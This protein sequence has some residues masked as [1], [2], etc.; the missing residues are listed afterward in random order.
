MNSTADN[1]YHLGRAPRPSGTGGFGV[2]LLFPAGSRPTTQALENLFES[3]ELSGSMAQVSH[4]GRDGEGWLEI[5]VGGLIFDLR[6]LAPAQPAAVCEAHCH[7]GFAEGPPDGPLEAIELAPGPHIAA[8]GGLLPVVRTLAGLAANLALHLPIA[9][10]AWH[11]AETWLEP[12]HFSRA[13][14]NWLAGGTF[15]APGLVALLPASD[16]GISSRGLR[17]FTGQEIQL[18]SE[19][20]ERPEDTMRFAVRAVDHLVRRGRLTRAEEIG[21]AGAPLLAEP[22]QYSDLVWVWRKR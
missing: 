20:G 17:L 4:C 19:A 8:G 7:H 9:A 18:A 5:L 2:S 12:R 22:S 3:L 11:S 13:V 6:G 21:G 1:N 16:S 15:P 10:V 14:L